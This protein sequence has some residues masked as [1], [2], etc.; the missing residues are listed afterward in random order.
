MQWLL[1]STATTP[2]PQSGSFGSACSLNVDCSYSF[3]ECRDS[4]CACAL[5]YGLGSD[6]LSCVSGKTTALI[7]KSDTLEKQRGHATITDK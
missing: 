7:I 4:I 3:S 2:N 5:G 6:S 1:I